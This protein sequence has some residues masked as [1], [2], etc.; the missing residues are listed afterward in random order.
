MC[1]V[2]EVFQ[3]SG[4][5]QRTRIDVPEHNTRILSFLTTPGEH[6][7]IHGPSKTGKSTLWI[8]QIGED[9]AIKIP[10]NESTTLEGTYLEIADELDIFFQNSE[11]TDAKVK[12]GFQAEIKAK[13]Y[14][15]LE[16]KGGGSYGTERGKQQEHQR[17]TPP[18]IGARNISKFLKAADKHVVL[19]NIHYCTPE[20]RRELSKDLHNFSDYDCKWIIVGVQHQADQVFIENRDLVGRLREIK[21]GLFTL[22]QVSEIIA[23]GEKILNIKF[24]PAIHKEIFNESGGNAALV[25]DIAKNICLLLDITGRQDTL[26]EI[27]KTELVS[28]ACQEIASSCAQ[29]YTKFCDDIIKGG[30]SDGST[31][32]YKWFLKLVRDRIIPT[33]GMLNTEVYKSILD[34]GHTDINQT[35]ITQGLQYMNKLQQKRNI[36]PAVLEYDNDKSRLYLLDPYFRFS[37]RWIPGL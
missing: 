18:P 36:N 1:T 2:F 5:P 21:T 14:G 37:L 19:E 12:A 23:L 35:S 16:G 29:V 22:S 32:K 24:S 31:Q 26:T 13:I 34:L 8:S 28:Q 27:T 6:L 4:V 15:L 33:A 3:S 30:R 11:K 17:L 10:C 20:F 25:Q 9:Y 7:I